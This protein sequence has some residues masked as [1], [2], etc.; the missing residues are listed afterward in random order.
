MNLLRHILV[1]RLLCDRVNTGHKVI[2]LELT[3]VCGCDC[4]IYTVTADSKLNAVNLSVLTC[5]YNLT[6]AIADLHFDKAADRVADLLSIS[7]HIL[8]AV[9]ILMDTVRPYNY[10][11]ADAVF[12]C[13]CDGKFLARCFVHRDSQ[14]VSAVR[15]RNTVNVCREIIIAKHTVCV[16]ESSNILASVPFKLVYLCR[17]A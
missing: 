15:E 12:L 13:G 14:F 4:L 5:L 17:T 1:N 3:A 6:R 7:D 10:T 9:A 11:S 16:G 2:K 8:N